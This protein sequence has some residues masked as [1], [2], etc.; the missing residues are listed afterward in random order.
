MPARHTKLGFTMIDLMITIVILGIL[1]AIAMPHLTGH[2]NAAKESSAASSYKA[3][4]T[5]LD[6]YFNQKGAWPDEVSR[7]LFTNHEPV[8]MPR[9]WQLQYHPTDGRLDL[10]EL[11]PEDIEG[12]ASVLVIE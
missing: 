7:E 9:G 2:M 1:A 10:V 6:L 5:A 3:V 11:A 4:R 8:N 12:A